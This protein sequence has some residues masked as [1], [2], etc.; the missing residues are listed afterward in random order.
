MSLDRHSDKMIA[1]RKGRTVNH[2]KEAIEMA[3]QRIASVAKILRK[4]AMVM[5]CGRSQLNENLQG[6]ECILQ[7]ISTLRRENR[8]L[9]VGLIFCLVLSALPYI[10][11]F[12]PTVIKASKVVTERIE[13]AKDGKTVMSIAVHPNGNGLVIRNENGSPMVFLGKGVSGGMVGVYNDEGNPVSAMMAHSDGGSVSVFNN[14]GKNV[15]F[16]AALPDGGSNGG[17]VKVANKDGKIVAS[18]EV[19][20]DNGVV[21][22]TNKDDKGGALMTADLLG[23]VLSVHNKDSFPLVTIQAFLDGGVVEVCDHKLHPVASISATPLCGRI[24]LKT[25]SGRTV[26]SAP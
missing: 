6:D 14:V 21:R 3:L 16:M 8:F 17:S 12:Q 13:F 23:G 22:V 1:E 25:P 18:M 19:V 2:G 15:A 10:A 7:Q 11:G 5:L 26:W 9:K 20:Q 24:E 4:G